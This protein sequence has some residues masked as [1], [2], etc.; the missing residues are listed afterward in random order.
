MIPG[1]PGQP[2]P[3]ARTR[4]RRP[5]ISVNDVTKTF[6]T[7][8]GGE[9][10]VLEGITLDVEPGEIVALLGESGSGKS[11]LLRCIAGLVRPSSGTISYRGR[12]LKGINPACRWCSRRSRCCRG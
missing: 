6:A 8:D 9:L 3:P 10:P 5:L 2:M 7:R 1:V 12:P 4:A 11:T